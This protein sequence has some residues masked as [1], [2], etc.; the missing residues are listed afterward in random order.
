MISKNIPSSVLI[1]SPPQLFFSK[2][3]P[4]D[5]RLG[6]LIKPADIESLPDHNPTVVILGYP[7]DDGIRLSGGRPGAIEAPKTIRQFLYKMTPKMTQKITVPLLPKNFSVFDLG[8][9]RHQDELPRRHENALA[10]TTYLQAK[11]IK[12]ITLG[13]GHDYGYSDAAGFVKNYLT[14]GEKP[15]VINF[16]AHLDVRPVHHGFNSGTPFY[17]LLSEFHQQ[18]DFIEIGLQPQC[19]SSVHWRW[20]KD[21]GAHLF[22]LQTIE[23][24]GL[25]SLLDEAIFQKIKKTTPVFISFDIDALVASEAGGCSQA[26][27]T[28]LKIA[29]CLKFLSSLYQKSNTRGLGIYE[30]SPPLDRDF[31][32]SKTAA[33][34]IHHFLFET[35]SL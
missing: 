9:L 22:D 3:D 19:N 5:L 13:G 33:L 12:T 23:Q 10:I 8:D 1:A 21:H 31:Q 27:M 7:D 6:D 18:I 11:N 15:V 4:D 24:K 17:R 25:Q 14:S 35:G 34:L 29:E 30:V 16:D 32:T 2:N 26:W 20:A 28:G